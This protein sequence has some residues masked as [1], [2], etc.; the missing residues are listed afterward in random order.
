MRRAIND[1]FLIHFFLNIECLV[2]SPYRKIF[3]E[4]RYIKSKDIEQRD[5][6]LRN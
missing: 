3:Y 6:L 2:Q 5:I 4:N 1:R